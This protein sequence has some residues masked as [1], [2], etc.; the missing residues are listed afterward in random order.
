MASEGST[1]EKAIRVLPFNGKKAEWRMWSR[2]FLAHAMKPGY[3]KVMDGTDKAPAAATVLDI[4]T[5]AG[6]A[7][8]KLR[9]AND[10]GYTDL[11]LSQDDDVCFSLVDQAKTTDQPEGC[12]HTAW[13]NLVE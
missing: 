10:D 8:L 11:L 4:S 2:K 6:K 1:A 13:T 9:E 12:L 5:D 7:Q 3:L